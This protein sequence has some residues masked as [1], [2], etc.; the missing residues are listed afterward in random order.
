[1]ALP[2]RPGQGLPIK[3]PDSVAPAPE[4]TRNQG[5][6]LELPGLP[7]I[8]VE[9]SASPVEEIPD[10]EDDA[11]AHPANKRLNNYGEQVA[12]DDKKH[13][14][15]HV[16]DN[17]DENRGPSRENLQRLGG[18]VAEGA[19]SLLGQK[20]RPRRET[21]AREESL[22]P[23]AKETIR[24]PL[25]PERSKNRTNR[26]ASHG[27]SVKS[28]QAEESTESWEIDPVTGKKFKALPG[29]KE[30][31]SFSKTKTKEYANHGMTI[32]DLRTFVDVDDDFNM[33]DL[34]GTAETFLPHLRVPPDKEEQER[35]RKA[36][37]AQQKEHDRAYESA[38]AEEREQEATEIEATLGV[39]KKTPWWKRKKKNSK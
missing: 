15:R 28:S 32:T 22:A 27:E 8:F 12:R 31:V 16:I 33:D 2:T 1:M 38:V 4:V 18:A 9:Q 14:Y 19:E 29:Y 11:F 34:K 23:Q 24:P 10:Y 5:E 30:G 36:R 39:K 20:P 25:P 3:R 37:A 17:T 21:P 26:L 13:E 7:E 35:L 6:E